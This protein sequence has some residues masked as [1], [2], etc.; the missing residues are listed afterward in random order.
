V[1]G[2]TYSGGGGGGVDRCRPACWRV[3]QVFLV[4]GR[5][6]DTVLG[7]PPCRP[8]G[9]SAADYLTSTGCTAAAAAAAVVVVVA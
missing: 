1:H 5:E 9:L 8:P 4:D 7:R 6:L 3:T 2:R